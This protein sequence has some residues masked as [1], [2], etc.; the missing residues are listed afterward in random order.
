MTD[1]KKTEDNQNDPSK[2]VQQLKSEN[3]RIWAESKALKASNQELGGKVDELTNTV[4]KLM[5]SKKEPDPDYGD[6][7][8]KRSK[9]S[10]QHD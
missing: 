4:T 8:L 6:N 1:E 10:Q 3:G 9:L 2:E 5:E 7:L